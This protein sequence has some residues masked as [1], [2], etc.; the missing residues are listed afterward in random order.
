MDHRTCNSVLA[1]YRTS[2]VAVASLIAPQLAW[3]SSAVEF[4][5][6]VVS[7]VASGASS[8]LQHGSVYPHGGGDVLPSLS[9]AR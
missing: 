2:R 3:L 7:E 4:R 5:A 6:N 1:P 9:A 8:F